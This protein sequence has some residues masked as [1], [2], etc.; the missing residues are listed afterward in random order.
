[1]PLDLEKLGQLKTLLNQP[2]PGGRG[3]QQQYYADIERLCREAIKPEQTEPIINDP[4]FTD[5]DRDIVFGMVSEEIRDSVKELTRDQMKD[6]S[7]IEIIGYLVNLELLQI[8]HK[9]TNVPD[10]M[11]TEEL[12]MEI[13]QEAGE[14]HIDLVRFGLLVIDETVIGGYRITD[15]GIDV[16]QEWM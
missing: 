3:F 9:L 14:D 7:K 15:L 12:L 13:E 10:G 2:L 4:L 8:Y 6:M 5:E 16:L 1:M 11:T